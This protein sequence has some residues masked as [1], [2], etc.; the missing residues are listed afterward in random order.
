V[1]IAKMP[2]AHGRSSEKVR[3]DRLRGGRARRLANADAD[4][5][6]RKHCD[7]LRHPARAKR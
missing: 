7:V 5:R 1:P 3:D 6:E 2:K 4:A